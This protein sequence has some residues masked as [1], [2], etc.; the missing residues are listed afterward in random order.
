MR[1]KYKHV[2]EFLKM[3]SE[4]GGTLRIVFSTAIIIGDN[5]LVKNKKGKKCEL[6][7]HTSTVLY[8]MKV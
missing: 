4:I 2:N 7:N 3:S 6:V 1:E 8:N 5:L